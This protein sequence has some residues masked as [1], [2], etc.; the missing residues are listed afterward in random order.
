MEFRRTGSYDVGIAMALDSIEAAIIL[1]QLLYEGADKGWVCI[2][3]K[4]LYR[5]TGLKR[6]SRD[7]ARAILKLH[8]LIMERNFGFPCKTHYKVNME[9]MQALLAKVDEEDEEDKNSPDSPC[10]TVHHDAVCA[11][12]ANKGEEKRC[13]QEP[14]TPNKFVENQQQV[15]GKSTISLQKIDNKF[16]GSQQPFVTYTRYQ[17]TGSNNIYTT[18]TG[19]QHGLCYSSVSS[20]DPSIRENNNLVTNCASKKRATAPKRRERTFSKLEL[21]LARIC[22]ID[23]LLATDR[24]VGQ[25]R[26]AAKVLEAR[27][28]TPE[29]LEEFREWFK[30][31]PYGRDGRPPRL[32]E[33]RNL[34]GSFEEMKKNEPQI[35]W[36]SATR[37]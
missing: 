3:A 7:T 17:V 11:R 14:T 31:Y 6:C 10:C 30:R 1:S 15:C 32:D 18:N 27:K 2:P 24:L 21:A 12:H 23:L 9:A 35:K 13:P 29:Q 19:I 4:K 28:I 8:G 22:A 25:L 26:N 36:Y 34:W 16:A 20:N 5:M 33:V 37:N